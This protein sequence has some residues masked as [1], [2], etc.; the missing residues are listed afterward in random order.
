M[1]ARPFPFCL[2]YALEERPETTLGDVSDWQI[3][4]KWDGIRAQLIKRGSEVNLWSRGEDLV[5]EQFPDIIEEAQRWPEKVV[6]DGELLAWDLDQNVPAPLRSFN[7]AWD[8]RKSRKLRR[9]VPVIFMAYD[10][11]GLMELTL[12]IDQ[13]AN[14]EVIWKLLPAW[15][16]MLFEFRL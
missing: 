12:E 1:T 2:A 10:A 4:W 7:G 16:E 3:E 5:S 6:L 15:G 8:E 9:E 13:A 14:G 11:L